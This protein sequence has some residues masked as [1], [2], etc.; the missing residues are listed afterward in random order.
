M[1]YEPIQL[2]NEQLL[3]GYW[4]IIEEH[5]RRC[6]K[7]TKGEMS[8]EDIY[9]MIKTNRATCI[10]IANDRTG[11][12]PERNAVLTLVVEPIN[13]PQMPVISIIALGGS[14]L[15]MLHSHYWEQFKGWAFMN[16]ARAIEAWVQPGMRRVIEK[17]EF[18]PAY[19]LMRL[20]LTV[21]LPE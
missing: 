6:M 21:E 4:P 14:E 16:G 5:I 2:V 12:H 7:R 3:A 20:D 1:K 18:K 10:V 15:G 11:T 9:D 8:V 13:Y 17:W 19:T